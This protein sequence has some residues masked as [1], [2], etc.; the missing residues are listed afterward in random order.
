MRKELK[1]EKST[2]ISSFSNV[3]SLGITRVTVRKKRYLEM[4]A[5][6][7]Q[8]IPATTLTAQARTMNVKEG[9]NPMRILCDNESTVDIIKNRAMGTNVRFTKKPIEITSIGGEPLQ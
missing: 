3:E 5:N 8:I 2:H 6:P 4:P 7:Y 9:I 1:Q